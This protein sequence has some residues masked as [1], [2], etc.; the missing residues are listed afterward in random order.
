MCG[1]WSYALGQQHAHCA[2][3]RSDRGSGTVLHDN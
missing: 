1:V 2:A 3:A